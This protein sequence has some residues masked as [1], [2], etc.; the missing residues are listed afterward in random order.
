MAIKLE[1]IRALLFPYRTHLEQ[2]IEYMRDVIASLRRERD[3]IEHLLID[4]YNPKPKERKEAPKLIPVK[5]RGWD[6]YRAARKNEPE[7]ELEPGSKDQAD[8][9]G[10][11][12]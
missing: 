1:Q 11:Q 8:G 12:A 10:A 9:F 6:A 7:T 5:P 3:R 2:E 4:S